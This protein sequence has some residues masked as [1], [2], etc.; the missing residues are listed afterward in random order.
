[1]GLVFPH[2]PNLPGWS[3]VLGHELWWHY[4]QIGALFM[5]HDLDFLGLFSLEFNIFNM[6]KY[7]DVS[8]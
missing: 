2:S 6:N 5:S 1:M 4:T 8:Q 7:P 3:H